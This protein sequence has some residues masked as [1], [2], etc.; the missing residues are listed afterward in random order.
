MHFILGFS[1]LFFSFPPESPAAA[2]AA[3][4]WRS[5]AL[6]RRFL[7]HSRSRSIFLAVLRRRSSASRIVGEKRKHF[8]CDEIAEIMEVQVCSES[9]THSRIRWSSCRKEFS[10]RDLFSSGCDCIAG[11]FSLNLL[12]F[13]FLFCVSEEPWRRGIRRRDEEEGEEGEFGK[14][15]R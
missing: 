9:G 15:G 1:F 2:E 11:R 3:I 7:S 13:L 5:L 12:R 6:A 14:L 4:A 10:W 8:L